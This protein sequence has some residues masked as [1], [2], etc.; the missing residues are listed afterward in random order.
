MGTKPQSRMDSG[1]DPRLQH[2]FSCVIS[3]PSNS[4]KTY[5]VKMLLDNAEV[6]FSKEIQNIVWVYSCWQPLYDELLKVRE[7]HFIEGLPTS[8]CDDNLLPIQKNNLLIIDD[9]MKSASESLEMERVFTQYSHHRNLSAIYLVQNMFVK[10]KSSR[11]INLNTN[12]LILFKN[13]RDNQQISIL[14]RQ[15]YPGLS[16]FFMESFKDATHPPFGYLLIDFK[17]TT[18]EDYRLRTG[19]FSGDWPVVYVPKKV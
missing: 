1:F 19:L 6:V 7:I 4:G 17:A 5:F 12:Y 8:L 11:T 16:R 18:P 3:G 13:P 2:P 14:G 9:L 15:I 10:G